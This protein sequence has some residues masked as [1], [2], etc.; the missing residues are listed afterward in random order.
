MKAFALVALVAGLAAASPN[1]TENDNLDARTVGKRAAITEACT[2]GYCT[3]N[4]GTTG[5][6]G[7]TTTTVSTLAQITAV[8]NATGP[9]VIVVSGA[10]SGAAK[11][12]VGS[13]K[14][15][16]GLP[17][18]SMSYI[19]SHFAKLSRVPGSKKLRTHIGGRSYRY[20]T[21]YPRAI[22]R[23]CPKHEDLQGLG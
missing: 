17:G 13:D 20:R 10:I 15:I 23:H 6:T 2:V 12:E 21:H 1:P 4:G 16:I 8:A 7:G 18:S 14:S 22:E 11:V 3:E 9:Y 5:G 19:T